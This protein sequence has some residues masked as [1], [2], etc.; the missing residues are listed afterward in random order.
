M[1][2]SAPAVFDPATEYL[3]VNGG[4]SICFKV[5][6]WQMG[7]DKSH[8]P[9]WSLCRGAR[10]PAAWIVAARLGEGNATVL[11][12]I[13]LQATQLPGLCFKFSDKAGDARGMEYFETFEALARSLI[14]RV[15]KKR[16]GIPSVRRRSISLQGMERSKLRKY[17]ERRR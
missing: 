8:A 7:R 16:T 1:T 9:R 13:L 10:S 11:D 4:V 3:R 5:A 15:I 2:A 17:R 12:Y 14:S 6:P